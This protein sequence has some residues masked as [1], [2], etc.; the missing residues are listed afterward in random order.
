MK[1]AIL[2]VLTQ[3]TSLRAI[4]MFGKENLGIIAL[5]PQL[6][7]LQEL[8]IFDGGVVDLGPAAGCRLRIWLVNDT[9]PTGMDGPGFLP[10]VS[11]IRTESIVERMLPWR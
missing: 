7:S 11:T 8:T 3:L 2:S 1:S 5:I 9:R 6:T 10:E 4:S